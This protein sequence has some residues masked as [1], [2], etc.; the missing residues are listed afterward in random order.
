MYLFS[1]AQRISKS[2]DGS[3]AFTSPETKHYLRQVDHMPVSDGI[4]TF[5]SWELQLHNAIH[6]VK[7]GLNPARLLKARIRNH[8]PA[9]FIAFRQPFHRPL[10]YAPSTAK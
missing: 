3:S 1:L 6:F 7:P 10:V 4:G 8:R 2:F 5:A 9:R